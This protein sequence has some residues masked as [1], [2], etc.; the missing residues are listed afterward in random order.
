LG[1]VDRKAIGYEH[2]GAFPEVE[3]YVFLGGIHAGS[4]EAHRVARPEA[5]GLDRTKRQRRAEE[6]RRPTRRDGTA[7]GAVPL[8]PRPQAIWNGPSRRVRPRIRTNDGLSHPDGQHSRRDPIPAHPGRCRVLT[9]H[10]I[11]LLSMTADHKNTDRWRPPPAR[12]CSRAR[13]RCPARSCGSSS[14]PPPQA[15]L[16]IADR[17][18]SH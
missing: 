5:V 17:R 3:A 7:E 6:D 13:A 11:K 2:H 9:H 15:F 1:A 18:R 14:A 8:V 16:P 12:R 10:S 4:L